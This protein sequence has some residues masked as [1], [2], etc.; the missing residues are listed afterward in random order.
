MYKIKSF[1][2]RIMAWSLKKKIIYGILIFLLVFIIYKI[3]GPKDNSANITSDTVKVMN[4]KRTVLATGQVT[5]TTDLNLSFSNSG[6]VKSLKVKVGDKVKSDQI[7]ATLDQGNE[8]AALTSARG[9][10]QAARARYQRVLDGASSEEIKLAEV[11]LENAKREYDRAKSQ[12][13]L[14]VANAYSA[15]LN[16]TPE[17]LPTFGGSDYTAPTITGSYTKGLEGDINVTL[18]QS[19]NGPSFNLSGLVNGDGSVTANIPQPLGDTGLYISFPNSS[20]TNLYNW[21]VSIP[22]KKASNYSTNY[23]AYQSAL[24]TRDSALGTAQAL[25]D[26]RTVEL[27]IKKSEARQPEV[28]LAL[29]DIT[30]AEGQLQAAN[31]NYEHTIL[32]APTSGTI[33]KV[34]IKLGE[35]AQALKEVMILQDVDNLYLEANINEAN[36]NSIKL[37][38]EVDITFDAFGTEQVFKGNILKVDPASTLISGVVNYKVTASINDAP[39]LRPGMTANMTILVDSKDGVLVVPS[40]SIITDKT[41]RKIIRFITNTKTKTYTEVEVSTGMEGDGGLTEITEGLEDGDEIVLLIKS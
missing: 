35:L 22:N 14:L 10:L 6:V 7:L 3:F 38:A 11:A 25:I 31:A 41:G 12:Q 4:L 13:D 29:A 23:N 28:D 16:S 26:Q 2:G 15:L 34:D 36:I 33:T 8:L 27:S 5:S 18:F 21:T 39:D 9:G 32:R 17:A 20:S 24:K 30:S 1:G 19:G 37:G 40:R